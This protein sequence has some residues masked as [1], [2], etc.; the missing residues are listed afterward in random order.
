M[1]HERRSIPENPSQTQAPIHDWDAIRDFEGLLTRTSSREAI[2]HALPEFARDRI[3]PLLSGVTSYEQFAKST[4]FFQAHMRHT[5]HGSRNH[6]KWADDYP[7]QVIEYVEDVFLDTQLYPR[8]FP[9]GAGQGEPHR[10][11]RVKVKGASDFPRLI[12]ERCKIS[13]AGYRRIM[14][15]TSE[16]FK[17]GNSGLGAEET[18]DKLEHL[19]QRYNDESDKENAERNR[20]IHSG[21]DRI[22]QDFVV[23]LQDVRSSAGYRERMRALRKILGEATGAYNDSVSRSPHD[24]VRSAFEAS[25]KGYNADKVREI[26]FMSLFEKAFPAQGE[27]QTQQRR[28]FLF[29]RRR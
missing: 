13:D 12:A 8:V 7:Q 19:A 21:M 27:T 17:V 20:K 24:M 11:N 1:T 10:T 25:W 5:L 9:E 23:S 28:G 29:L 14:G 15:G 26:Y 6:P 3:A 18:R 22:A 16:A 2:A 4:D